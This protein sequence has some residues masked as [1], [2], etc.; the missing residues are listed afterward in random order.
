MS[1]PTNKQKKRALALAYGV[2]MQDSMARGIP[3]GVPGLSRAL[4]HPKYEV[5]LVKGLPKGFT[6][7]EEQQKVFKKALK[8]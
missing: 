8:G 5:E 3:G 2:L 4:M 6:L 7:T 1:H